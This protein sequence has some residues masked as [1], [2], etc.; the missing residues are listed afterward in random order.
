M[1]DYIILVDENKKILGIAPKLASHNAYT[2]LHLA[3]SI[4]LFNKKGE[5]LLQQRSHKKKTW[6][7]IWSH[8]CCGHQK[9]NENL[10]DTAKERL[11][12]EMGI[13]DADLKIILPDFR[14]QCEMNGIWENEICPVFVGITSQEPRINTD[15]VEA[16]QWVPWDT[17]LDE[18]GKNPKRYS[19]WCLK[20]TEALLENKM[21]Q[22]FLHRAIK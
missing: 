10:V 1:E 8:S 4:F 2:P 17:W 12:F 18:M 11:A 22:D 9:L 6:P 21:F 7:L 20:E 16:Y 19:Y 14:Y 3:F 13:T 5:V 15:E